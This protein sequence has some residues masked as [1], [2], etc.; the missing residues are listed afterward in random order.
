[1]LMID[2]E[3]I[4]NCVIENVENGLIILFYV[5]YLFCDVMW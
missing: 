3:L 1:M 2:L 5:M 4:V